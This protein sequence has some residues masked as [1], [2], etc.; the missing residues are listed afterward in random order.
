MK[1]KTFASVAFIPMMLLAAPAWGYD[2]L[3]A[4]TDAEGYDAQLMSARATLSAARER[5]PQAKA[6][7]LPSVSASAGVNR[8]YADTNIAPTRNYTAQ[9]YGINLSYPLYRRQNVEAYEQS[10]LQLTLGEAQYAQAKQDLIVRVAQ[11]YMDLLAAQD[12]LTTILAQKKAIGEQLAAAKRNFEVGT[13][14]VTDQQEAQARY[15]LAIAQELA[16]RNELDIR[17]SALTQLTGKPVDEV[18]VVRSDVTLQ[19]PTP[20]VES[21]WVTAAR[22]DNYVVQQARVGAEIARRE[23]DRQRYAHH[24]TVDV[25]GQLAH[26]RNASTTVP[27]LNSNTASLG[28]QLAIPLYSGGGIDARVR[29]AAANKDKAEADIEVAGRQA[30]QSTRQAFLGVRSGLA[31]VRALEAAY[32]SSRLALESNKLGYQVGVRINVDVL[33]AQQQLFSTQ[34]DMLKARYDVLLNGLRL[35]ASTGTLTDADVRA[36]NALLVERSE[37]GELVAPAT[38]P[39]AAPS[40][41]AAQPPANNGTGIQPPARRRPAPGDRQRGGRLL[42]PRL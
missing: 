22:R 10:K 35:K 39:A 33:N 38:Q 8:Q 20:S 9:T 2:L 19:P 27:N 21:E 42:K 34:R 31:Q 6:G 4:F 7:L 25:V 26:A 32:R 18:K 1:T 17:R 14:T 23:I 28:L 3:Q 36:V 12:N 11:A 30:E 37:S 41:N 15:D 16:A 13:A 24:P 40:S 29:E 5:V